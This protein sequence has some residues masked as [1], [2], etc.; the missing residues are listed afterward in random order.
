MDLLKDGDDG[1]GVHRSDQAA[2]EQ[3]LQQPDVQLPYE[4]VQVRGARP[5][6]MASEGSAD[7]PM[8]PPM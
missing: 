8:A 6:P 2:E 4:K 5:S 7:S 3:V 1:H